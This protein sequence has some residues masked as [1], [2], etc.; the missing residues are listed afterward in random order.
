MSLGQTGSSVSSC[1]LGD[2]LQSDTSICNGTTLDLFVRASNASGSSCFLPQVKSEGNL[3]LSY[4]ST[5]S[6]AQGNVFLSGAFSGTLSTGGFT[7][8]SQGGTDFFLIKYDSC[9]SVLW[10]I[11]GGSAGNEDFSAGQYGKGIACDAAGNVFLAGRYNQPCTITGTTG[12]SFVAP[13]T[14]SAGYPNHQDGFLIKLD[15]TGKILWG[16]TV[17]GPGNDGINAVAVDGSGNPVV[18]ADFNDCCPTA[19]AGTVYSTGSTVNVPSINSNFGTGAIIKFNAA[20][21][22]LWVARIYNREVGVGSLAVDAGGSIYATG[23]F[24]SWNRG[25][26][27]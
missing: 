6:D 12:S 11:S 26:A 15:A 7:L 24:R 1:I 10:A 17:R 3:N 2:I 14:V 9:G 22:A 13:Y 20:G 21:N 5:T 8:N 18:S 25:V 16:I 4:A 27:A 23:Y 19:N